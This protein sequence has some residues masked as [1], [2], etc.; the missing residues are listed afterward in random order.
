MLFFLCLQKFVLYCNLKIIK[1]NIFN[2]FSSFHPFLR[3]NIIIILKKIFFKNQISDVSSTSI[4]IYLNKENYKEIDH[5]KLLQNS[6][7]KNSNN[8]NNYLNNIVNNYKLFKNIFKKI[9]Y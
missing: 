8:K 4:S 2:Y 1:N 9:F 5:F 6:W 7:E 3:R